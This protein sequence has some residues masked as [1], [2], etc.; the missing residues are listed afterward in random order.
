M[1]PPHANFLTSL[2]AEATAEIVDNRR[3]YVAEPLPTAPPSNHEPKPRGNWI[4]RGSKQ[5]WGY[6]C[7]ATH[8]CFGFVSLITILS[9]L[10]TIPILQFLSL[11]Y[12]LEAGGRVAKTGRLR[13]GFIGIS[14]AAAVGSMALGVWLTM[15]PVQAMSSYWYSSSLLN[16]NVGQTKTLRVLVLTFGTLGMFHILWAGF[17]GGKIRHFL[18]P[19]PLRLWRRIREGGMYTEASHRLEAFVKSLSLPHYFWLGLRGFV[20]ATI[21][22]FFPVTMLA[23][24]TG[25]SDPGFGGLIAF[26]GGFLLAIVLAYLP[27]LQMRL[28]LTNR[29]QSQ[30]EIS[31][32]RD[33]FKRAPIAFWFS[34]LVTL[35]LAVP[36]YILK[37]ELIPREAAWLPSLFFVT[38][39]FPA[40]LAV[41]WAVSR[42]ER[43]ETS[44]HWFFRWGAWLG[45]VPV[46]LIYALIVF[47]TQFTSWHGAASLY[48]QHAFL[49]PVPFLGY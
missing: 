17:R 25:F 29:F 5:V 19:A 26:I 49:V 9:V 28:P 21:W 35:A 44:R 22:L 31:V 40:R 39:M 6:V 13:S 15:L 34:L 32:V 18:W 8:W 37:A 46:T 27:F 12:L 33:R 41:G 20:G 11:G 47:F 10:A 4:T 45:I 23:A 43:R 42:S 3:V 36:L 2:N 48:E 30:F 1:N 16:G 24:A 38:M 7:T 14:R